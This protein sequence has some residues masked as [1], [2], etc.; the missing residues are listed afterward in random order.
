MKKHIVLALAA[1][2]ASGTVVSAIAATPAETV[3]ARQANFK[4]LGRAMKAIGEESK[5]PAPD[6]GVIR[7]SA[8]SSN[9]AAG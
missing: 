2:A 1:S 8:Q 5:K 9:Q 6:L 3:A 4:Q 7:A